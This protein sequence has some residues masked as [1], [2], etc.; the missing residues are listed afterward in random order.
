MTSSVIDII[1]EMRMATDLSDIRHGLDDI[2]AVVDL[3]TAKLKKAFED[4]SPADKA[5]ALSLA[6]LM[7]HSEFRDWLVNS[8]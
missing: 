4:A 7:S 1:E 5:I 8:E 2:E 3:V 6:L